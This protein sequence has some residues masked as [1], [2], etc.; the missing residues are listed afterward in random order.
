MASRC[1]DASAVDTREHVVER[2][3]RT[4]HLEVSELAPD[5]VTTRA[6]SGLHRAPPT[7]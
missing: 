4:G 3:E 7:T 2:L 1:R 6:H 5:P